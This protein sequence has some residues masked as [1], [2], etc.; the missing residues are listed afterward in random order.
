MS[1]PQSLSQDEATV[2]AASLSPSS[3]LPFERELDTTS[4][5]YLGL[6]PP[7]DQR[8]CHGTAEKCIGTKPKESSPPQGPPT[9]TSAAAAAG[10]KAAADYDKAFYERCDMPPT[11][12][13][14]YSAY[15]DEDL[16]YEDCEDG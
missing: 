6:P 12:H 14:L 15:F 16:D 2:F 10:K 11:D 5:A 7:T 8:L 13:D 9:F 1:E 4:L 3:T